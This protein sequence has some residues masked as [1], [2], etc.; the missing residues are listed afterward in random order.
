MKARYCMAGRMYE[1]AFRL[2]AKLGKSYNSAFSRAEEVA[3]KT[4]NKIAK[5]GATVLGG[6]GIADMANTY[7]DFQQSIANTGAIAGVP[8][9]SKEFK[10][11]ETA[12]LEAGKKTTKTAQEAADALGYMSLA[13]WTTEQSISGLMPVLRASEATGADLAVTSDLVTDSMSA[14]GVGVEQLTEYLDMAAL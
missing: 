6:I 3:S 2:N 14:M 11:L 13:G 12:A 1:M 4:F 7:K 8:K 5:L 9:G 10:A